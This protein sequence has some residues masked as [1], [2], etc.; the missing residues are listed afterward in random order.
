[1]FLQ[2]AA[3]Q[4]IFQHAVNKKAGHKTGFLKRWQD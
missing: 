3:T 4:R 1:M 2:L